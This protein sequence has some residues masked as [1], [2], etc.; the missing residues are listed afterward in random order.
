[1]LAVLATE[2]GQDHAM[3]TAMLHLASRKNEVFRNTWDDMDFTQGR[4]RLMT[5]NIDIVEW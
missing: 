1:M 4:I 3:L 2:K 5:R